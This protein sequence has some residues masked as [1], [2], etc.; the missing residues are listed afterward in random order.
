MDNMFENSLVS[1]AFTSEDFDD[2]V[3]DIVVDDI[4]ME[5]VAGDVLMDD[6]WCCVTEAFEEDWL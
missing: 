6:P 1:V 3:N 2:S 4:D 5:D